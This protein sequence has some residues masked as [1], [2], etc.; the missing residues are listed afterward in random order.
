LPTFKKKAS[1]LPT[2]L[3]QSVPFGDQDSWLDFLNQHNLW[4]IELAKLT[5]TT[6]VQTDD[7]K[8]EL[9]RHAEMHDQLAKALRIPTAYDLVSYDL[10]ERSSYEGFMQTHGAEHARLNLASGL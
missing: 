2:V 3:F 5:G 4:H 6:Y 7:L 1:L 9:L 10:S 8:T